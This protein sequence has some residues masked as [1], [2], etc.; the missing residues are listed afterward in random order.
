VYIKAMASSLWIALCN[1]FYGSINI[2]DF[3]ALEPFYQL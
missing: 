3:V 1:R 2:S